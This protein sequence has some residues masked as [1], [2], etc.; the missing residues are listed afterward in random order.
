MGKYVVPNRDV[1]NEAVEE[2]L[3][4]G[5]CSGSDVEVFRLNGAVWGILGGAGLRDIIGNRQSSVDPERFSIRSGIVGDGQM[6]LGADV[7]R[8]ALQSIPSGISITS[9][10]IPVPTVVVVDNIAVG[11]G[12]WNIVAA[13]HSGGES[14]R[15]VGVGP[16]REGEAFRIEVAIEWNRDGGTRAI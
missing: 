13:C 1:I 9:P 4:A 16:H 12:A 6:R 11:D 8:G 3:P 7:Y 5:V 2:K 14:T 10:E 15:A